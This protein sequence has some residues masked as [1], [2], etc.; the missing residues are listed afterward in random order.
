MMASYGYLTHKSKTKLMTRTGST[1]KNC[2][3]KIIW[4]IRYWKQWYEKWRNY[5][6]KNQK[7]AAKRKLRYVQI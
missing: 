7:N 2:G 1:G 5:E 6:R 4:T 3:Y